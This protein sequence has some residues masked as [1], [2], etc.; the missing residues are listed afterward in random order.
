MLF[1]IMCY[2]SDNSDA[3]KLRQFQRMQ[4]MHRQQTEE[5]EN[6]IKQSAGGFSLIN[7]QWASFATGATAIIVCAMFF[8]AVLLCCW[9]RSCNIRQSRARHGQLLDLLRS[10]SGRPSEP[11][12]EP[13]VAP[14]MGEPPRKPGPSKSLP[15]S[16]PDSARWLR[17]PSGW[18]SV[19]EAYAPYERQ[20][21][22]LPYQESPPVLYHGSHFK[23]PFSQC[24]I[25]GCGR[26][27]IQYRSRPCLDYDRR[28]DSG[29]F[30]ELDSSPR[31]SGASPGRRSVR[32]TEPS[33][34]AVRYR[35]QRAQSCQTSRPPSPAL[36]E[37]P[38][39]PLQ[40]TLASTPSRRGSM[41]T[42]P[43]EER[44]IIPSASVKDYNRSVSTPPGSVYGLRVHF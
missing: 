26:D 8:L 24:G 43:S 17:S 32:L 36:G 41:L 44:R 20:F 14:G 13:R 29:R 16:Y 25:P 10:S 7:I 21:P 35:S 37:I 3:N 27:S 2:G 4:R 12:P 22:R 38:C 11:L 18:A 5:T 39:R 40:S 30:I 15:A 34:P 31:S 19:P 9:I 42:P 23:H 1:F 28:E 6:S 33:E